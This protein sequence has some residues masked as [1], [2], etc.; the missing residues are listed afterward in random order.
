MVGKK[1]VLAAAAVA[2]LVSAVPAAAVQT[3]F[4]RI[5][6]V[7]SNRN[8]YFGRISGASA[9]YRTTATPTSTAGAPTQVRFSLVGSPIPLSVLADFLLTGNT[10]D[11]IGVNSGP[12]TQEMDNFTFSI[13]S[14]EAFCWG[15]NC[16]GVGDSLLS[17]SVLNS[18][19]TG[20]LGVTTALFSGSTEGGST[21]SLS[22]PL[23]S[24]DP[25]TNYA[26]AFDLLN[27]T[28]AVGSAN[29]SL[30]SFRST[31][32]GTFSTDREVVFNVPEPGTWA[33]MVV[34]MGLVGV[35]RRRRRKTVAA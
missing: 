32:S 17:G 27:M 1:L 19:I 28:R 11:A 22:S 35:A 3:V 31:I 6:L 29:V 5:D 7:N 12:Y 24:F 26:F 20:T 23:V 16:F 10:V 8:F 33:L 18:A 4:A 9:G 2:S 15:P 21:I 14:R 13:V 25:G 30:G 34:G